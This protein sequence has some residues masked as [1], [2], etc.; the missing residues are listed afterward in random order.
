MLSTRLAMP[1][2]PGDGEKEGGLCLG[3][4]DVADG[5]M[6]ETHLTLRRRVLG[7]GAGVREWGRQRRL[8][9]ML[10][11]MRSIKLLTVLPR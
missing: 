11:V 3:A 6:V 1:T 7:R 9:G 5:G 8:S 2:R 4:W 10:D